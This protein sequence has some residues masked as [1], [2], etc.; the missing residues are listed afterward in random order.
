MTSKQSLR[1][2]QATV[3]IINCADAVLFKG[4]VGSTVALRGVVGRTIGKDVRGDE[5]DVCRNTETMSLAVKRVVSS[6]WTVVLSR[7]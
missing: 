1:H 6:P 7:Q 4:L 3:S 5:N 2:P